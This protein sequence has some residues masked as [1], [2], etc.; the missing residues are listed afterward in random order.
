MRSHHNTTT[1]PGSYQVIPTRSK[2]IPSDTP[3]SEDI[4]SSLTTSDV[5]THPPPKSWLD[6]SRM[7]N[8]E[9]D[10]FVRAL[11]L[12]VENVALFYMEELGRISKGLRVVGGEFEAKFDGIKLKEEVQDLIEF[13][14]IN[15]TGLRKI[16]KKFDKDQNAAMLGDD[17]ELT[18]DINSEPNLLVYNGLTMKYLRKK[19]KGGGGLGGNLGGDNNSDSASKHLLVLCSHYGMISV[20]SSLKDSVRRCVGGD[21]VNIGELE[22]ATDRLAKWNLHNLPTMLQYNPTKGSIASGLNH[23]L[24]VGGGGDLEMEKAIVTLNNMDEG[25]NGAKKKKAKE[26]VTS[27]V[28]N[29][30]STFLYMTNYYV[31]GPTSSKYMTKLGGHEAWAGFLIGMT[32]WAA[33]FSA[34]LYSVWTNTGFRR[35]LIF[36][37]AMLGAGNLL[38]ASALRYNSVVFVLVGRAMT[39]LGGPRGINRRYIADT[40]SV[41]SRTSVSAAFVACGALGMAVGPGLAV[42]L[43]HFD[44][45]TSLPV[46]GEVHFNGMTGPGY[47]MSFVWL[48]YCVVLMVAFKEPERIDYKAAAA[49]LE[50]LSPM[51]VKQ[52]KSNTVVLFFRSMKT[53]FRLM[54]TPV[55]VCLS[56]LFINKFIAE[57]TMSSAPMIT[58]YRYGW[59]VSD[60]G[61]LSV[62]IG[63]LVVPLTVAVGSLARSYEDK[64]LLKYLMSLAILGVF[65]LIDFS[66]F[67]E[68]EKHVESLSPLRR[69]LVWFFQP[70]PFKYV[71]GNV[72]VFAGLQASE[73]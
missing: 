33:M 36:S 20:I 52:E 44:F 1:G 31:V 25:G 6:P 18:D 38:Y 8:L 26:Q 35:P 72:I 65:L 16:L 10:E 23:Y 28:L 22:E 9:E 21:G 57:E 63:L 68:S 27:L 42:F 59:N 30:F 39:G 56:L 17:T 71:L 14:G 60:V 50:P 4:E 43:E 53:A 15:L 55:V 37:A 46:Y 13:V 67:W 48:I 49:N 41:E 2:R 73:R 7:R 47:V 45:V 64:D 70:G 5:H 51:K 40:S 54:N 29:L 69:E 58:K 66:A 32:P 34:V 12:Q 24:A 11:D 3:L 62:G 61:S 19:L